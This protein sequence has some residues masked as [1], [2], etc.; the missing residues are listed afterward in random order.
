MR[1]DPYV[2]RDVAPALLLKNSR[3]PELE[4]RVRELSSQLEKCH[5]DSGADK[6]R[7]LERFAF[8][9][10]PAVTRG[11]LTHAYFSHHL[12]SGKLQVPIVLVI[13]VA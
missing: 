7:L 11:S 9:S 12:E 13:C 8:D 1:R 2:T 6:E 5:L 3:N 10:L 4:A